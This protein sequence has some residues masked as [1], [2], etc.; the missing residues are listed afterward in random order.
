MKAISVQEIQDRGKADATKHPSNNELIARNA[1]EGDGYTEFDRSDTLTF[2]EKNG[3]V[4]AIPDRDELQLD[5]DSQEAYERFQKM[6]ESLQIF[7]SKRAIVVWDGP[8][9]SGLPK[10]HIVIKLPWR[11]T[12][13]IRIA[14]QASM[15][16]DGIREL[17]N[18]RRVMNQ[19]IYPIALFEKKEI[20]EEVLNA[21]NN[22]SI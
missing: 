9:K 15:G 5:I 2:A 6:M 8:S 18:I 16:S 1:K 21:V 19:D 11:L 12:M 3:L 22:E 7:T 14:L 17:N 20:I 4:V 10:R 13:P